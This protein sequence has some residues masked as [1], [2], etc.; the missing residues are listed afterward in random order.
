MILLPYLTFSPTEISLSVVILLSLVTSTLLCV[1]LCEEEEENEEESV[2]DS[3]T[4]GLK[5][6][7]LNTCTTV[8]LGF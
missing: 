2:T 7:I 1:L 8:W 4:P 5:E 6:E 3:G